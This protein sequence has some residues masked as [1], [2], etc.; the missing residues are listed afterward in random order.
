MKIGILWHPKAFSLNNPYFDGQN[1]NTYTG[2]NTGNM[3]YVEGLRSIFDDSNCCFLP[4]GIKGSDIPSEIETLI[5]PA[6]NQLGPHTD[7]D[8]LA[9]NFENYQKPVI[10][11]GLG[12]QYKNTN[13]EII[14]TSGT[15]RWLDVLTNLAPKPG[16]PNII[17]RGDFT[18]SVLDRLGYSHS[19]VSAG[20]PSQFINLDPQLFSKINDELSKSDLFS[21]TYN[22]SHYSWNWAKK[23]DREALQYIRL[24]A[25]GLVV[26]AP[27]EFI[28]LVKLKSLKKLNPKFESVKDFYE[29]HIDDPTFLRWL[30]QYFFTFPSASSWRVWLSHFDFNLGTR[31]HGTMLSLQTGVP[32][33]LITHDTR[34]KELAEKMGVPHNH[35]NEIPENINSLE[36]TKQRLRDFNFEYTESKRRSNYDIYKK[37]LHDNGFPLSESFVKYGDISKSRDTP[38]EALKFPL[39]NNI[40]NLIALRHNKILEIYDTLSALPQ[41]KRLSSNFI[42]IKRSELNKAIKNGY[43]DNTQPECILFTC[44]IE[45][46]DDFS[47]TLNA[48]NWDTRQIIFRCDRELLD[49]IQEITTNEQ[50]LSEN[51]INEV[52]LNPSDDPKMKFV[53]D[54]LGRGF[55]LPIKNGLI[56]SSNPDGSGK[57]AIS[58]TR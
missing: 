34:T 51:L 9:K 49:A 58:L 47:K 15:K 55:K 6:A 36:F 45:G 19:F 30:K 21:C 52:I 33:F 2:H 31:I 24:N 22:T 46:V 16:T 11:I 56:L 43:L 25:G 41:K 5:F 17:T 35:F 42:G 20:C 10:A 37:F 28:D 54:A 23:I 13:D 44:S 3:A 1:I 4:W 26:Q 57:I 50:S 40:T 53:F 32:S 38:S 39:S 48:I 18:A 29:D 12:A 14:L 7:L 8:D 27:G